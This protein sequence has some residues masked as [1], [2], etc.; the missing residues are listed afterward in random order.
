MVII[1]IFY[2]ATILIQEPKK[3]EKC[4]PISSTAVSGTPWCVVWTGDKRVFFY[5]PA[6]K[7]SVWER[8]DELL[9]RVDVDEMV[10]ACP[11]K[12]KVKRAEATS[13][14]SP[15]I[16]TDKDKDKAAVGNEGDEQSLTAK[17]A[18]ADTAESEPPIKR[19]RTDSTGKIN[20]KL[21]LFKMCSYKPYTG[22]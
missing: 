5:N 2:L 16:E 14:T 1:S 11:E 10:R 7:T 17:S 15:V 20:K 21:F 4:R 6:N 3:V 13:T 8:P 19:T 18:G 22:F 9:G 12:G